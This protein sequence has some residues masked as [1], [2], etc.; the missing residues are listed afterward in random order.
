MLRVASKAIRDAELIADP[1]T[2]SPGAM[3]ER[4]SPVFEASGCCVW[5]VHMK[6]PKVTQQRPSM[7]KIP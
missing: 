2:E 3:M 1:A 4:I 6:A 5:A 7:I